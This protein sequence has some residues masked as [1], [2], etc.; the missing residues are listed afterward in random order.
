V[1]DEKIIQLLDEKFAKVDAR[2]GTLEQHID[3]KFCETAM[4]SE[5]LEIEI[6]SLRAAVRV[7]DIQVEKVKNEVTLP[8]GAIAQKF[9]SVDARLDTIEAEAR[10]AHVHIEHM[11]GEVKLVAEGVASVDQRLRRLQAEVD[12]S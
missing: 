8:S 9:G 10:L 1:E 6:S 11:R 7:V 4:K 2:F 3:E 12:K 5:R